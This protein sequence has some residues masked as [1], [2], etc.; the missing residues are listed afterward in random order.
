VYSGICSRGSLATVGVCK[1]PEFNRFHWSR[2]GL[3]PISSPP[4]E[5]APEQCPCKIIVHFLTFW[6]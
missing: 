4:P 6:F 2:G 1:T 5:Y 3:A